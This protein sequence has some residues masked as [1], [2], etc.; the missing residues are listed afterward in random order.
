M[1]TQED[2]EKAEWRFKKHLEIKAELQQ[3][4][5]LKAFLEGAY[6]DS[7]AEF[8]D[9]YAA[10]KV[11]WL[12]WGPKFKEW[13]E[14]EDLQWVEDATDRLKEIQ[15]KKLF[16]AQCLWR[17]EKLEIPEIKVTY[18]FYTWEGDI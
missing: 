2:K 7:R 15:Q 10:E 14:K 9:A 13:L 11:N 17:A 16:D 12:D 18:D 4:E 1:S 3:N 5:K 6:P 8:I